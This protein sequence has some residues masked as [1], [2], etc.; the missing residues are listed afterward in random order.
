MHGVHEV[1]GSSPATP[2]IIDFQAFAGNNFYRSRQLHGYQYQ[3]IN[4][5]LRRFQKLLKAQGRKTVLSDTP[6]PLRKT[7]AL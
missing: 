6:W 4:Q 3:Q 7:K 5:Q 2:T 1:V